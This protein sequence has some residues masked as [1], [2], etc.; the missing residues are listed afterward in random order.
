MSV[1][2]E[3][4]S[5][6]HDPCDRSRKNGFPPV[7]PNTAIQ[8]VTPDVIAVGGTVMVFHAPVVNSVLLP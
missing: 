5:L 1:E 8:Y 3:L 7:V 2:S 4:P 6:L